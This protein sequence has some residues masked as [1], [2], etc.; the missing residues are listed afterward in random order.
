MSRPNPSNPVTP[1]LQAKSELQKF[2]DE[3]IIKF[4][5]VINQKIKNSDGLDDER[6]EAFKTVL[7]AEKSRRDL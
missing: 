2:S 1:L 4:E 5:Q 3:E 7:N 6:I